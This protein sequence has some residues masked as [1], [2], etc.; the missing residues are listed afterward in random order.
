MTPISPRQTIMALC[1]HGIRLVR[2]GGAY[3]A[4][5]RKWR[6]YPRRR[7]SRRGSRMLWP[8]VVI[9]TMVMMAATMV[10]L[11]R[12]ASSRWQKYQTGVASWYGPGFYGRLTASGERFRRGDA[13][14][15]AAHVT[16]PFGSRVLVRNRRNGKTV[17]VRINDRGPYVPGRIIDLNRAAAE[18]LGMLADGIA[19]VILY[20]HRSP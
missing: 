10:M 16:L 15:T 4:H 6:R 20:M 19:P 12:S 18:H 8:A 3:L 5:G 7:F 17:V 1:R 13:D 9:A 2:L 14:F 11:L